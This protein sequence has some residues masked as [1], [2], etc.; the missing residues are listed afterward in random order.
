MRIG[1]GTKLEE[2]KYAFTVAAPFLPSAQIT[3]ERNAEQTGDQPRYHFAAGGERC[4]AM[5][6]RTP[7]GGGD[8]FLQG[9]IESPVFPEGK[10]HVAAFVSKE[11][12]HQMDLVWSAPR[13]QAASD[14]GGAGEEGAGF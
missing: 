9:H 3:M 5:W 10:L 13:K 4:G 14:D 11:G 2:G 12:A 8:T 1:I 6:K 7:R